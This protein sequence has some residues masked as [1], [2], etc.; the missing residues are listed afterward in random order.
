MENEEKGEES[1]PQK[2]GGGSGMIIGIIAVVIILAIAGFAYK[3][4]AKQTTQNQTAMTP[5]KKT[6]AQPTTAVIAKYTYKDGTYSAEG[7]YITHVGQKYIQVTVTL[8]NDIITSADVKNEADDKMSEHYQ[9]SF[10]SGYKTQVIG[11]DI[12]SV[13]VTKV[14]LSSLTPNGF[15]SAL[16]TIEK[17]AKS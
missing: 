1:T 12:S 2:S 14:A 6:A 7:D 8:K 11:K 4:N 17:Q 3:S 5:E 13:H 10:I 16:Q 15:N 9:D